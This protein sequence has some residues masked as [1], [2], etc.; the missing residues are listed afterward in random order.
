MT[1]TEGKEGLTL[2]N[3]SEALDQGATCTGG[4]D[5]IEPE[6]EGRADAAGP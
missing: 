5:V 4:I 3:H 6:W 1:L 2:M